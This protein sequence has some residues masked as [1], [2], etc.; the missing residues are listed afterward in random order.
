MRHAH[1][2][3]KIFRI[4][5]LEDRPHTRVV[6]QRNIFFSTTKNIS[7]VSNGL[8]ALGGQISGEHPHLPLGRAERLSGPGAGGAQANAMWAALPSKKR[9]AHII[10]LGLGGFMPPMGADR[11]EH[12]GRK[13]IWDQSRRPMPGGPLPTQKHIVPI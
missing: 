12:P 11:G 9:F 7:L 13:T 2:G 5:V 1:V 8:Y 10:S 6:H 3:R 4:L